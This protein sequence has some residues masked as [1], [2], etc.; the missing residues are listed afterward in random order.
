MDETQR[1]FLVLIEI[2][3]NS[4]LQFVCI[5]CVQGFR[6]QDLLY[7]HF[8]DKQRDDHIHHG[9]AQRN[10]DFN[11]FLTSYKEALN[12]GKFSYEDSPAL[13]KQAGQRPGRRPF[14][15]FFE[16]EYVLK[17]RGPKKSNTVA[18]R[19][20]FL[21]ELVEN[22]KKDYVCPL[23][24]VLFSNT[25]PFYLHCEEKEDDIHKGLLI[26]GPE[27]QDFLRYYYMAIGRVV[28]KKDL[29]LG[30]GR[31]GTYSFHECF[32]LALIVRLK[33]CLSP[34]TQTSKLS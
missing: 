23:C 4:G 33:F 29:P 5:P 10:S 22:A 34:R 20:P 7:R 19:L 24:L 26:K 9:F 6:H 13:F 17:K 14:Y 32:K 31:R 21:S 25:K 2:S 1:K 18:E 12:W 11:L 8:D 16:I 27:T 30:E 28:P 15:A 3:K